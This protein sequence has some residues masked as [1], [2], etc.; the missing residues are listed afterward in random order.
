MRNKLL[1]SGAALLGLAALPAIAQQVAQPAPAPQ[2]QPQQP[3]ATTQPSPT[4][5]PGAEPTQ[6]QPTRRPPRP[7]SVG[8]SG[9]ETGIAEVSAEEL[10]PPP[11]P[12]EIPDFARRDP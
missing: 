7:S 3:A 10:P 12:V 2:P 6:V 1:L 4:P 9:A 8:E 11:P 5:Q